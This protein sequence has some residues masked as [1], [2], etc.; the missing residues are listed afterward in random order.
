MAEFTSYPPNTPS[1]IDLAT[2]DIE[3]SKAFYGG[4]FGWTALVGPPEAG[5][6]TMFQK[7]G[8]NVAGAMAITMEGQPPAWTTYVN[9]EDADDTV[10]RVKKAGGMVFVEPMDVM[11]VG[12]MSV[13]A[14]PTGAAIGVWQARAHIGADLANEPDTFCWNELQTRDS[15]AAK[16]FYH[17]VFGWGANTTEGEA[18]TYTEWRRGEDSI[19]GMMDMLAE[20][21]AEVPSYWLVYFAVDDCDAAVAKANELGATTLVP[22]MDVEPGRFSVLMDPTGATFAVIKMNA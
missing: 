21:P 11:D 22:P 18:M 2:P 13:F 14:D 19:G 10:D 4:L 3:K 8:K 6:Y 5:G 17:E 1:W 9:V 7:G 16:T 15:A 20:V 12:R